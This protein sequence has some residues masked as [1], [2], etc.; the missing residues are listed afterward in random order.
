MS[1]QRLKRMPT[2]TDFAVRWRARFPNYSS[3]ATL[4]RRYD[5]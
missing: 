5:M 4:F 1:S 2:I 3:L